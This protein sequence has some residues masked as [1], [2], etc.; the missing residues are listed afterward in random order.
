MTYFGGVEDMARAVD[1]KTRA[2]DVPAS[3]FDSF[4]DF[5]EWSDLNS[6]DLQP[7]L[8]NISRLRLYSLKI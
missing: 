4:G 5:A 6:E 3:R 1:R 2:D 8:F 7:L